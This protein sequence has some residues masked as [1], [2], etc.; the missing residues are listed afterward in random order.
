MKILFTLI[1]LCIGVSR[2]YCQASPR[3]PQLML[4]QT[5]HAKFPQFWLEI[6]SGQG[7]SPLMD[8]G[9][10][11]INNIKIKLIIE[12]KK[13]IRYRIVQTI[14]GTNQEWQPLV[15]WYLDQFIRSGK[16]T[17][18]HKLNI[19]LLLVIEQNSFSIRI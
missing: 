15:E 14:Y 1:A 13:I 4:A 18:N 19:T 2:V 3:P 7:M 16:I 5:G 8:T 9:G 17:S 12:N 6:Y 11:Y 10:D